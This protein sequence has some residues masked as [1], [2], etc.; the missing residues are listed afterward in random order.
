[1]RDDLTPA[2]VRAARLIAVGT[3]LLQIVL[4]PF[5]FPGG[6]SP[7]NN[8]ID[9]VV[10]AALLRLLGWHWAFLPTFV[11]ELVPFVDLIPTWTAAVF[12]ATRGRGVGAPPGVVVE[13]EAR[14]VEEPRALPGGGPQPPR[15]SSGA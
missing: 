7:V 10:A 1:M 3:D 9:V 4:L 6:F 2:T 5:F 11:A 14:A 12:L 13:A 8:V 15:G